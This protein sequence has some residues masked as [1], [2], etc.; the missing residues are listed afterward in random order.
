MQK[1]FFGSL[2]DLSF[3][4]LVTTK[5]IKFIYIVSLIVIAVVALLFVV[6]AFAQSAAF[7]VLT[8]VVLAPLIALLYVIYTRV[9]LEVIIAVFRLVEYNGELVALKRQQL[10]I[11][12]PGA[13]PPAS[14]GDTTQ[15]PSAPPPAGDAPQQPGS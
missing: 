3:S 11:A 12:A 2:F 5:V 1:G 14:A 10:G 4:S 8:L 7:G 13:R 9:I 6:A 15:Q